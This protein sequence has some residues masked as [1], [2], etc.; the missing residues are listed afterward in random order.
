MILGS[1]IE[2]FSSYIG[3]VLLHVKWWDYS[4]AWLN[5]QGRTCL[6]Y[7]VSWGFLA[8]VLIRLVN[9]YVDKFI[10][11]LKQKKKYKSKLNSNKSTDTI[12]ILVRPT[13]FFWRDI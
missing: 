8:I 13:F 11:I 4:G 5:I 1:S 6:F 12:I 3:E 2:Y 7:A 9:P 10:N